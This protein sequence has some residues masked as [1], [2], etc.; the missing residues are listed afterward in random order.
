MIYICNQFYFRDESTRHRS[1]ILEIMHFLDYHRQNTTVS[2]LIGQQSILE[3]NESDY[4]MD[5]D[6]EGAEHLENN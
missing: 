2:K 6:F 1:R 3:E 5:N 4:K